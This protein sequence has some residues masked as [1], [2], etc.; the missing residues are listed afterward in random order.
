LV[1]QIET[2]EVPPEIQKPSPPIKETPAPPSEGFNPF[3]WFQQ[4]PK[5]P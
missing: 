2:P 3:R 4:K 5:A 1:I